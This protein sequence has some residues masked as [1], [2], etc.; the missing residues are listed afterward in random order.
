MHA[1]GW[2]ALLW[3]LTFSFRF[4]RPSDRT[5]STCH[6]EVARECDHEDRLHL[7]LA[8]AQG[9]DPGRMRLAR[10]DDPASAEDDYYRFDNHR[11]RPTVSR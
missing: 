4:R 1:L 3:A 10:Y 2:S 9:V 6:P 11:E 8:A 5:R 7:G